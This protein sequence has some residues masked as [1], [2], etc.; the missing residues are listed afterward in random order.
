MKD[1]E[2][3]LARTAED[4]LRLTTS[5]AGTVLLVTRVCKHLQTLI[6]CFR[7]SYISDS[8]TYFAPGTCNFDTKRRSA[9]GSTGLL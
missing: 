2:H 1:A 8:Q 6:E 5:G 7:I 9:L 3:D 4:T